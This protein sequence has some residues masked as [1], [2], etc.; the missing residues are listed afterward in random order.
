MRVLRS[1]ITYYE[2]VDVVHH[3]FSTLPKDDRLE[4]EIVQ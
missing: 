2:N 4:R 3:Q 1:L